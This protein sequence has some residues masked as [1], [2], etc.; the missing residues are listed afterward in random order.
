[1]LSTGARADE[2]MWTFDH[3]PSAVVGARYGFAPD[4]AWLDRVRGSAVRLTS[5]CSASIV[6][7]DGLVLTNHHCVV[8]CAQ[9]LS[10]PQHDLVADGFTTHARS[11]ERLCPGMQAEIVTRITDVTGEV[12]EAIRVAGSSEVIKARDAAMA[13]IEDRSCRDDP[14]ARC[15]VVSLYHGGQYKLY[16]YRKYSD[17]RLVFAPELAVSFF[18]GDPDNFNFPRYCLDSAFVRLYEDGRPAS[19]PT[20]LTWR[21]TAPEPEELVFVAGNPGSTDRLETVAQLKLQRDWQQPTREII[22][23]ELRGRLI[24]YSQRGPDEA[25]T[26][27]GMLFGVEN[28]FKAFYGRERSLLDPAFF[29]SKVDQ[30][31][32]LRD[33]IAANGPLAAATGDPWADV[34]AAAERYQGM[35]FAYGF[36]EVGAGNGSQLFR[37]ARALVRAAAERLKPSPQRLREYSDSR[38]PLVQKELL[39]PRPVYPRLERLELQMWLSKTREFLTVDDPRVQHLLGQQSPEELADTLVGGTALADP[40]VRAALWDGGERAI[41]ASHDPLIRFIAANDPEARALRLRYEQQVEGPITQAAE[42]IARARFAIYGEHIYPDATFTL[43]LSYGRVEGW[44]YQG[45]TVP[46]FTDFGGLYARATAAPPFRLPRRWLEAKP[47]LNM[48]TPLNVSTSNDIIGGN[49][50][51]PLIDAQGRVA[52]AIFDGNIHSLGGDYGYDPRLNRAIA[53]LTPAISAALRHVYGLPALADELEAQ[54][55]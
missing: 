20:H 7:R 5:G 50:G 16:R 39:D 21:R 11:E 52:G 2:G 24:D 38:L 13:G 37:Y 36:L 53:V 47:R 18:G 43:R 34:A 51:S 35:L 32:D 26:A 31:R 15:Q 27:A 3:F 28:S 23:S 48:D 55:R 4:A 14:Q 17:V 41:E 9:A 25:R 10:T 45:K 40:K 12:Q 29:A 1:M 22:L 44:T 30:E 42:K 49:S 6:T 46:P 33:K 19:T 8:R 54:A